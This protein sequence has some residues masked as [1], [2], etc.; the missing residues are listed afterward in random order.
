VNVIFFYEHADRELA[1]VRALKKLLTEKLNARCFILQLYTDWKYVER[2]K[3]ELIFVPYFYNKD[4]PTLKPII[5]LF[6]KVTVINLMWEQIFVEGKVDSKIPDDAKNV[7]HIIWSRQW[8][9]L[10]IDKGLS[11]S[12]LKLLGNPVLSFAQ[13]LR[14]SSKLI[15]THNRNIVYIEN[16]SILFSTEKKRSALK[17]LTD[18]DIIKYEQ[19]QRRNLFELSKLKK[20]LTLTIKIRPNI[21][22]K[23]YSNFFFKNGKSKLFKLESKG[24]LLRVLSKSDLVLTDMSTGILEAAAL[25][26]KIGLLHSAKLPEIFYYNWMNYVSKIDNLSQVDEKLKIEDQNALLDW[27]LDAEMINVGYKNEFLC[28]VRELTKNH[29]YPEHNLSSRLKFH[30]LTFKI[31]LWQLANSIYLFRY[32]RS[33]TGIYKLNIQTHSEDFPLFARINKRFNIYETIL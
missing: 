10:L 2:I 20:T 3:P 24:P 33:M 6:E 25:G 32:F 12:N 14:D 11:S 31:D 1:T 5:N 15:H 30:L 23:N 18:N 8:M 4:D 19:L 21:S 16:S 28:Y 9:K 7:H 27:M 29:H 22:K 17:G 13:A 26:K